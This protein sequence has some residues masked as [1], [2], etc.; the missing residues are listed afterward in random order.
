MKN[1]ILNNQLIE[2]THRRSAR[3][4]R[5]RLSIG[6]KGLVLSTPMRFSDEKAELFLKQHSEWI[7]E[8][9]LFYR[10]RTQKSIFPN[11]KND[12]LINK[13]CA[14][15]LVRAKLLELNTVYGFKYSKVSIRNQSSRWG[16]CSRNGNLNFNYKLVYLADDL[17]TY[18]IAHEM[19]HLQEMNHGKRFWQLVAKT[20]PNWKILRKQLKN[21]Y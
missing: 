13:S 10:E 2:F 16:S 8:K 21:I 9:I 4:R 1:I 20:V 19:S 11:H 6:P 7:L 5:L 18:V 12:F 14:L 3:S 15:R 17:A